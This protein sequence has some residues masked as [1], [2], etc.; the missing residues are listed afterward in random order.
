MMSQ[1]TF[2]GRKSE[3]DALESHLQEALAGRSKVVFITGEAG[4]GKTA[5]VERFRDQVLPSY[6]EVRFASA[7]CDTPIGGTDVGEGDSYAPFK[8]LIAQLVN[9]DQEQGWQRIIDIFK[10]LG[11]A[12]LGVVPGIG[13]LLAA[14]S[15]TAI[16]LEKRREQNEIVQVKQ[17]QMFQQAVNTFKNIVDRHN[18]LVLFVDDWQWADN[19]STKLLFHLARQLGDSPILLL[20][21]FRPHDALTARKGDGHPILSIRNEMQRY[22][23][24]DEISLTFLGHGEVHDYLK[25]EFPAA[26]FAPAFLDWLWDVSDGSPL[27]LTEYIKLL[28]EEGLLTSTGEFHGD[29]AQIEVPEGAKGVIKER[30]RRLG[31]ELRRMLTYASI[32]GENFT[33]LVL[34]HLLSSDRIT[35]SEKLRVIER[36]HALIASRGSQKLLEEDTT[37]YS[38]NHTLIYR[39][40]YKELNEEQ[41]RLLHSKILDEFGEDYLKSVQLAAHAAEARYYLQEAHYALEAA[42]EAQESYAHDEV[43]KHCEQGLE[44]LR[45]IDDWNREEQRLEVD[46]LLERGK[47]EIFPGCWQDAETTFELAVEK[48]QALNDADRLA[49]ALYHLGW[50]VHWFGRWSESLQAYKRSIV[51]FEKA[52]NQAGLSQAYNSIAGIQKLLGK[53]EVAMDWYDKALAIREELD[54]QIGLAETYNNVGLI[55]RAREEYDEAMDWLE[56]SVAIRKELGDRAGLATNYGNIASVYQDLGQY[57]VAMDWYKK[58]IEIQEELGD[59]AG[60][61]TNHNGIGIIHVD[62]GELENAL[63]WYEKAREIQEDLGEQVGLATTY[64]NI[65]HVQKTQE[66]YDE[67]LK[68]YEKARLILEDLGNQRRLA[69]TYNYIG[70]LHSAREEYDEALR[71]YKKSADIFQRISDQSSLAV[72]YSNIGHAHRL[73]G[74]YETALEW[75]HKSRNIDEDLDNQARLAETYNI[76]GVLHFILEEYTA[77]LEWYRQ[78]ADIFQRIGDQPSLAVVFGNIGEAYRLWR[79]HEAALEWYEKA[80]NIQKDLDDPANLATLYN[81]IGEIHQALEEYEAALEWFRKSTTINEEIGNRHALP[82]A[83]INVGMV[84]RDREEYDEVLKWYE[85]AR[86][87]QE[88]LGHQAEVALTHNNIAFIHQFC[89]DWGQA[90]DHFERSLEILSQLGDQDGARI[91]RQNLE[92]ARLDAKQN[93]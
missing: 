79:E 90:I 71:W 75:Y 86:V 57:D 20:G 45:K 55:H 67:A 78:S 84:Y 19:S 88:E 37:S 48:A 81:N 85:K 76:I 22:G 58:S 77:A 50:T 9:K 87:I 52:D 24:V 68:W 42:R 16:Y 70:L 80:C 60:L 13:G 7:E 35:L 25:K 21:T 4:I 93:E 38:F 11:P 18:P 5:L 28:Q 12:W 41:R 69:E 26:H 14:S 89:K 15:E 83:Y 40:F 6:P 92:R 49:W 29:F 39:I 46:L 47:T 8:T 62:R 10:E 59:R 64:N 73:L 51:H 44:A 43:L 23:L 27:F 17:D 53:R 65:G 72:I 82:R 56:K 54:D 36:T 33:T 63:K 31:E 91:V 32:E 74:E 30:I 61:A 66:E 3:L 1:Q 2:V 34:S